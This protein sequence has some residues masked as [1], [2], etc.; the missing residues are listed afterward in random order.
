MAKIIGISN[1]KGGCGKSSVTLNLAAGLV[2]KGKSVL[3]I[4][5]DPQGN[6][7][8]SMGHQKPDDL[9]YTLSNVIEKIIDDQPFDPTAGILE[10]SEGVHLMPANIGLSGF[11]AALINVYGREGILKQYVDRIKDA[12]DYIL[13]DTSP[14]LN[15][16]TI[17]V[18]TASD[19]VIIP[20]TPQFFSAKGMEL[21]LST[22]ARLVRRKIN[23]NLKI[24]G[25]LIN[26]MDSRPNFTKEV[27]SLVRDTYTDNIRVFK[28][29]IPTSIRVPESNARGISIFKHDPSGKVAIAYGEF[30]EELL[31]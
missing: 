7:S 20:T 24:E 30:T 15:I 8:M 4:D 13:I 14:S 12:Y 25:I 3:C 29:E 19:S 16:L 1:Q 17:N 27:A 10:H 18:L 23:T 31:A 26:M 21:L 6:L 5:C 28:T 22:Y 2:R 11:E 9:P